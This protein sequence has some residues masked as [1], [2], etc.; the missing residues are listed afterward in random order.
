L[1]I[2]QLKVA[3]STLFLFTETMNLYSNDAGVC[4]VSLSHYLGSCDLCYASSGSAKITM[5]NHFGWFSVEFETEI[6][7]NGKLKKSPI[8]RDYG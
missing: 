6:L 3:I 7:F 5:N 2:T 1:I 8:S 4:G